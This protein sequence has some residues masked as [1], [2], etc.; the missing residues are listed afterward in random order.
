MNVSYKFNSRAETFVAAA[1]TT[2]LQS[3]LRQ[4]PLSTSTRTTSIQTNVLQSTNNV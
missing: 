2:K 4:Q 3:M 1:A